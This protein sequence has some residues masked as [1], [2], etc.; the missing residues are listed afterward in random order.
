MFRIAWDGQAAGNYEAE[1]MVHL[2][3][4]NIMQPFVHRKLILCRNT[5]PILFGQTC[6]IAL[7]VCITNV[8]AD[9]D[10]QIATGYIYH[11]RPG[12][13]IKKVKIIDR[14]NLFLRW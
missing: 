13:K 11:Y 3:Y 10:R 5:D 12:A 8:R 2:C 14:G 4:G 1:C 9:I 7:T 6:L